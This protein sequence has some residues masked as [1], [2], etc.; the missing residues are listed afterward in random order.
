MKSERSDLA[1]PL[2]EINQY[3]QHVAGIFILTNG[4]V[5]A[6]SDWYMHDETD[7]YKLSSGGDTFH[8]KRDDVEQIAT[9]RFIRE[10][11]LDE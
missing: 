7:T 3:G 6:A 4:R 1:V 9:Q 2:E 10:V 5:L 8:I 11:V